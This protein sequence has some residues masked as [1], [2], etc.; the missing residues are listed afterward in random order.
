MLRLF[1][2]VAVLSAGV[3]G[4]VFAAGTTLQC[5]SSNNGHRV[6]ILATN[7]TAIDFLCDT[8]CYV[9]GNANPVGWTC[10]DAMAPAN[11]SAIEI[12]FLA[13]PDISYKVVEPFTY[14]C[15][16]K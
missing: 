2:A 5:V 3:S 15:K 12:C 14:T 1:L 10:K 8:D 16:A 6:S 7:T 4:P 13:S 11:S 9:K